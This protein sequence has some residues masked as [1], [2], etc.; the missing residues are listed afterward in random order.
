[1]NG[2]TRLA[3][4]QSQGMEHASANVMPSPQALLGSGQ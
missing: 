1:M 2:A 3:L 4:G